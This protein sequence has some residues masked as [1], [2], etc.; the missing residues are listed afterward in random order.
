MLFLIPQLFVMCRRYDE[1]SNDLLVHYPLLALRLILVRLAEAKPR[2]F[3]FVHFVVLWVIF[4]A[5]NFRVL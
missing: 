3:E 5:R 2:F 4:L 1:S